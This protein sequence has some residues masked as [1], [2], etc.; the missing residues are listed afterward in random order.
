M[1]ILVA[2][3]KKKQHI[4]INEHALNREPVPLKLNR[5]SDV[6]NKQDQLP[7]LSQTSPLQCL[8]INYAPLTPKLETSSKLFS[9]KQFKIVFLIKAAY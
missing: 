5:N 4:L 7:V 1:I 6:G 9:Y 8:T 2:Y 3:V